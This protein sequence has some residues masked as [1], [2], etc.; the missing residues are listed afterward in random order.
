VLSREDNELMCRVG[1]GTPMGAVMRH[2]WLPVM[3]SW[4]LEPDGAP[5]KIRLLGE[6][7]TAFRQTDGRVGIMAEAC[8]HRGA[9]MFFGRNEENGLRCVY[10]GWKF[11]VDGACTDMPNEPAESN[12][13]HKIHITSYQ[14]ADRG[15]V[16]WAYMGDQQNV[17]GLP[18]FEW[19]SLPETQVHHAYKGIYECNWVQ[20]L[21]GDIDTC[22]LYF[23]H[24]RLDPKD[25]PT[26]GVWHDDKAP[27]LETV[28][29]EYGLYYGA[30]RQESEDLAY[31][32][33]TQFLFP[34]FSMFPAQEDGTVPSHM[35]TP[36]DDNLTMHWGVRW[37]PTKAFN[38]DRKLVQK[39]A[40][41]P[42]YNGMGPMQ[43]KRH[44]EPFADWWPVADLSND[45]L[46]DRE[47]QRT[48][49]YT[50]I[51]TVRLQDAAVIWSMGPIYDRTEEHLGTTDGMIIQVRRKL[52]RAAKL[53]RDAGT[54]PPASEHPELYRVRSCSTVLPASADWKEALADWH[55][56]RTTVPPSEQAYAGRNYRER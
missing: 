55:F 1:P 52:I 24:G 56:G 7:L 44:G 34:I 43:P 46:M 41:V 35:Y 36:I 29:T 19:C 45:F 16:I 5:L 21:E 12:F 48:K 23:L 42:E 20:A 49:N 25:P 6:N 50:G 47:V 28:E 17:P 3:Y 15:G 9:S 33:T 32:R 54:P 22:H 11:D 53:L 30:R 38:H 13:R 18:D 31:W 27:R 4:E 10:H 40:K 51:P 8:P 39:V 26:Y 14:A 37:H 2:Y